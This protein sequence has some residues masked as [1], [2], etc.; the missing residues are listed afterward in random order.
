MDRLSFRLPATKLNLRQ[1]GLHMEMSC[2]AATWSSRIG[3]AGAG[4]RLRIVA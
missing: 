4:H 1:Q 3:I 2:W